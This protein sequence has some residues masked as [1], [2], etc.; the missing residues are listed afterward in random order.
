SLVVLAV[1]LSPLFLL[2]EAEAPVPGALYL[3]SRNLTIGRGSLALD[4]FFYETRGGR[5]SVP[6]MSAIVSKRVDMKLKMPDG[7]IATVTVTPEG[8][9]YTLHFSAEPDTDIV[10]WGF[11]IQTE[12]SEYF[13]GLMERVVDG[14]QDASWATGITKAMDLRGQ[15]VDM[16]LKPTT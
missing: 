8:N 4:S 10:K 1:V 6:A 9:N 16:I 13:T 12:P 11:A 7:R 5:V 3:G 2:A 14:P 15:K